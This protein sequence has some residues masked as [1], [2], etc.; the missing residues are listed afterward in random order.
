MILAVNIGNTNINLGLFDTNVL[1][2]YFRID[3]GKFQRKSKEIEK[4]WNKIFINEIDNIV[5]ASVNPKTDARFSQW[6]K[7]KCK[8]TPIKIG[9]DIQP[10]IHV[11][12]KNPGK[13]GIDRIVNA[14]AAYELIGKGVIVVDAG[15]AIT[16]DVVSD[17]GEFL[18]GV[19]SPGI[20]MCAD[21][22]HTQTGQ[23][24]LVKVKKVET[25]LGKD[26]EDAMISGIYWGL[27]GT[28]NF[29]LE[30]LFDEL[31][32][33]PIVIATGGDAELLAISVK[34]IT[35][36]IPHLTLDGI[37]IVYEENSGD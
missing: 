37:R 14:V 30:R 22:L 15:T 20:K 34:Y 13:V 36:V 21:A 17:D 16:F 26:T 8:K 28:I 5:T 24:P 6:V 3:A 35:K 29:I 27:V 2:D 33:R 12:V 31:N 9:K 18:G 25:V 19:I 1:V 7:T 4:C 32:F 11:K 23:L 10:K